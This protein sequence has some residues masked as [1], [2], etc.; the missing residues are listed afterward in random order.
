MIKESIAISGGGI[1][2]EIGSE[3]EMQMFFNAIAK[4]SKIHDPN[5]DYNVILDRLYKRYLKLEEVSLANALLKR[6][7]IIFTK[8]VVPQEYIDFAIK[9]AQATSFHVKSNNLSEYFRR[10][11]ATAQSAIQNALY[12]HESKK[13]AGK[14]SYRKVLI[15]H[16]DIVSSTIAKMRPDELYDSLEGEP[17]WMRKPVMDWDPKN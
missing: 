17:Y 15:S 4:Y 11:F 1:M 16:S 9:N 6:I 3:V 13:K 5:T 10:Y 2:L 12:N 8:I 14:F 7:Q